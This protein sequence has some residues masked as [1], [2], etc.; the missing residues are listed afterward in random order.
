MGASPEQGAVVNAAAC[1][2]GL[3]ACIEVDPSGRHRSATSHRDDRFHRSRLLGQSSQDTPPHRSVG[4]AEDLVV[5]PD[6]RLNAARIDDREQ[7]A[8]G[9]MIQDYLVLFRRVDFAG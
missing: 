6:Q 7:V 9:W 5:H 4:A 3:S 1:V 2:H 8:A